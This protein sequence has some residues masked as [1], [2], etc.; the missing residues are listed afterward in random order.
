MRCACGERLQPEHCVLKCHADALSAVRAPFLR[1]CFL[2]IVYVLMTS[3]HC[4]TI[5]SSVRKYKFIR[6]LATFVICIAGKLIITSN[7][8]LIWVN[9]YFQF[10]NLIFHRLLSEYCT[11]KLLYGI[12]IVYIYM[13]TQIPKLDRKISGSYCYRC[14]Y[15]AS[16][17]ILYPSLQQICMVSKQHLIW[18]DWA[19]SPTLLVI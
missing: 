17:I 7:N 3:S 18:Y 2:Q 10:K 8:C 16:S 11:S 19:N 12:I 14:W 4:V 9:N 6:K 5:A 13:P 15:H 1:R